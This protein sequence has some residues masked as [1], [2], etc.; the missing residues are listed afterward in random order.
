MD[1]YD[2]ITGLLS[3]YIINKDPHSL[4]FCFGE[5]EDVKCYCNT[6]TIRKKFNLK[7]RGKILAIYVR[8]IQDPKFQNRVNTLIKY[9]SRLCAKDWYAGSKSE[10]VNGMRFH[11]IDRPLGDV[12]VVLDE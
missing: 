3:L 4:P 5:L 8:T 7:G 11:F 1:T 12:W 9:K 6:S 2:D 10:M